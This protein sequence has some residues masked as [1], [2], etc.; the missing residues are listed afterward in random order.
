MKAPLHAKE[1]AT[2]DDY[3]QNFF[4]LSIMRT[5]TLNHFIFLWNILLIFFMIIIICVQHKIVYIY[6]TCISHS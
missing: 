3:S 5:C 1:N 4:L 2:L 6:P